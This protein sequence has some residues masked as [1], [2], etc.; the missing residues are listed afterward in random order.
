MFIDKIILRE[1]VRFHVF[2]RKY[3]HC[4][5]K[6][7]GKWDV[8]DKSKSYGKNISVICFKLCLYICLTF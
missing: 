3:L 5:G 1:L 2:G 8:V 7:K 4:C 6:F